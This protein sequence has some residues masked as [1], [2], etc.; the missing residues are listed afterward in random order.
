[1]NLCFIIGKIIS[2]IEF[3]FVLNS[4]YTSI[5]IFELQLENG[6]RIIIKAYDEMADKCYKTLIES[7]MIG[8]QG[9]LNSN[10]EIIVND[11]C[12]L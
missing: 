4:K 2:N 9:E 6:S 5:V 8:I 12:Y 11:F 7:D 1:M 10:M 3:Q